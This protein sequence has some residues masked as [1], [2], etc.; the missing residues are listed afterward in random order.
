MAEKWHVR[1]TRAANGLAHPIDGAIAQSPDEN[2]V[3]SMW[4]P[5][6]FTFRLIRDGAIE[7]VDETQVKKSDG[8]KS[9]VVKE[10]TQ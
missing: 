3:W 6:Q 1:A 8:R 2:G 9:G 4:T 7:R 5:D 10:A